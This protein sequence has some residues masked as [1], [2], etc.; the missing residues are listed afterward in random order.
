MTRSLRAQ[1]G[2]TKEKPSRKS[3]NAW[4]EPSPPQSMD[5]YERACILTDL[6]CA[7]QCGRSAHQIRR[8]C[9]L[10]LNQPSR[11]WAASPTSM[12][13]ALMEQT[14]SLLLR[15]QEASS[16]WWMT[17]VSY[18]LMFR[19]ALT[20]YLEEG[21]KKKREREIGNTSGCNEFPP[22]GSWTRAPLGTG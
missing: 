9:S 19:Y 21:K 15:L 8:R 16:V 1:A 14:R 22:L 3:L 6:Y 11:R 5:G 4:R 13:T 7:F 10:I 17:R 20:V 18:I 2:I 12:S